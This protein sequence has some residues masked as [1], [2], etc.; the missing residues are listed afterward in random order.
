MAA[1][2]PL[3]QVRFPVVERDPARRVLVVEKTGPLDQH[4]G[5]FARRRRVMVTVRVVVSIMPV[6]ASV[7]S[8]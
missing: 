2:A 4:P 6:K 7:A 5:W 3:A 1:T 8:R